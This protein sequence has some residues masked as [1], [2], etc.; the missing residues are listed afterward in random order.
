MRIFIQIF[1]CMCVYYTC[2]YVCTLRIYI[3]MYIYIRIYMYTYIYI[4]TYIHKNIYIYICTYFYIYIGICTC[5]CN[6]NIHFDKVLRYLGFVYT[7]K[8]THMNIIYTCI[9]LYIM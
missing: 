7:H 6:A 4:F 2:I 1:F 8:Y 9:Y 3:F 5:I